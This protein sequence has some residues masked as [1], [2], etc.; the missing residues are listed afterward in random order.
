MGKTCY[1]SQPQETDR[2]FIFL[3]STRDLQQRARILGWRFL[4]HA[5]GAHLPAVP[6]RRGGH[7]SPEI[8]PGL[9][10]VGVAPASVAQAARQRQPQL[11][12]LGPTGT[13]A[14]KVPIEPISL[15]DLAKMD[16][17]TPQG[18]FIF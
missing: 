13:A 8:L 6:E 7:S 12:R 4:G 3:N 10:Q 11:S 14:F 16:H 15:F 9:L 18:S 17:E 5:G 1:L 2:V